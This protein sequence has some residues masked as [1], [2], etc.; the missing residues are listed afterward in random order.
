MTATTTSPLGSVAIRNRAE[1]E[2]WFV[3]K[4]LKGRWQ[5]ARW[6]GS[7]LSSDVPEGMLAS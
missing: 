1:W 2:A 6:H 4:Q 7:V 5:E 3:W